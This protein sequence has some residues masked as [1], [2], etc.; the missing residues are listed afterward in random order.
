MNLI[1]LI[2]ERAYK[3]GDFLLASGKTSNKYV[4]LSKLTLTP[5][6]L[7]AVLDAVMSIRVIGLGMNPIHY[8]DAVGGPVLGAVPIVTGL[9]FRGAKRSFFVRDKPKRTGEIIAGELNAGETVL[10]IEDVVTSGQSLFKACE[11]VLNAGAKVGMAM[12]ILDREEGATE[13]MAQCG[14]TLRSLVKLSD[15]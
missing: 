4:D 5:D 12:A 2:K 9:L 15:L 3:E 8:W 6:G 11:V 14:V 7:T 13:L 10:L 1:K